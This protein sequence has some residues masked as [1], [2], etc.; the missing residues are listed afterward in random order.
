MRP[1]GRGLWGRG[2]SR[3]S[4]DRRLEAAAAAQ[5]RRTQPRA[6]A[7]MQDGN[8][9]LSALQPEAGV[10]SLALPSDL[11]LDRRGT[12]GPE[13]ERLRAARVQEQVRARLLQLGQQQRHNGTAEPGTVA[14]AARGRR[15][16][17]AWAPGGGDG[18]GG[19]RWPRW[20]RWCSDH[21][22]RCSYAGPS[23]L[24]HRPALSH[25]PRPAGCGAGRRWGLPPPHRDPASSAWAP[26]VPEF[27]RPLWRTAG[28]SA[29][30]G[31]A[32]PTSGGKPEH[33]HGQSPAHGLTH[34]PGDS[35]THPSVPVRRRR[36]DSGTPPHPTPH[37]NEQRKRE[38]GVWESWT[39]PPP[40][41]LTR[42]PCGI[43][44]QLSGPHSVC[45]ARGWGRAPQESWL[46]GAVRACA[47]MCVQAVRM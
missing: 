1:A 7:A 41:R 36:P 29:R 12:Q 35:Q 10:C 43:T 47:C 27:P 38:G 39:E 14:G 44:G 8:F 21:R 11:Q 30:G 16:P 2:R 24:T 33:A 32:R 40:A 9:L 25:P 13:A 22:P 42:V 17:A 3:D 19:R 45:A 26:P 15:M 4:E 5:A 34:G 6:P 23:S 37:G 28:R 20:V 31:P 46:H 18:G